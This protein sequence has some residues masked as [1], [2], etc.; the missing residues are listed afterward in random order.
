MSEAEARRTAVSVAEAARRLGRG[1]STVYAR[2]NRGDLVETRDAVGRRLVTTASIRDYLA[3]PPPG[4]W[5]SQGQERVAADRAGHEA[6][7]SSALHAEN[8]TLREAVTR[9]RLARDK[10]SDALRASLVANR[11]LIKALKHQARATTLAM[12]ATSE[13][14]EV[15]TQFLIPGTVDRAHG[16]PD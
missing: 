1:R 16:L 15:V 8:V 6:Q 7:D 9:L 11:Y 4:S 10:E 3:N 12:N 5:V 13:M 14:D 2:L